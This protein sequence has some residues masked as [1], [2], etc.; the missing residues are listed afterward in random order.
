[1]TNFKD[2]IT[3]S[4][5]CFNVSDEFK[6]LSFEE[7]QKHV[8]ENELNFSIAC[9][10]I[11]GDL[12][13]GVIIR[14][15]HLLGT[16]NVHIFGRRRYD[17]RSTVGTQNYTS[18]LRH[19]GLNDDLTI[20]KNLFVSKM[21]EYNLV[22]IFVETN[23]ETLGKFSWNDKVSTI[24]SKN[25]KPCLIFGNEGM[26]IDNSILETEKEF[27]GSFCVQ[28]PQLGCIRSFNVSSAAS[29]IMW[30]LLQNCDF[31]K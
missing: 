14:S 31:I 6:H 29:I 22:P 8:S 5:N 26:G 24:F 18:I 11:T 9:L 23:G 20:D 27:S 21:N 1:M 16:N 3:E 13:I 4:N 15:A 17:K 30:D 28:I 12:N 7:I 25:K 19:G 2:M 10:S